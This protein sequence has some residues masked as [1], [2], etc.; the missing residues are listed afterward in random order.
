MDN[1]ISTKFFSYLRAHKAQT[2]VALLIISGVG[3]YGYQKFTAKEVLPQYITA[4]VERGT[5]IV[6]VSGTGQVASSNQIDVKPKASGT[7]VRVAVQTGKEVAADSVLIELDDSDALKTVRDA[8]VNLESAKLSLDKLKQSADTLSIL[9]SENALVSAK[10][11][12]EKLKLSQTTDYEKAQESKQKALDNITKAYEDAFNEIS[13]SFLDLP[14]IMTKLDDILHGQ[15]IGKADKSIGSGYINTSTLI[16]TLSNTTDD[17]TKIQPFINY[18][19]NDYSAAR[20]AYNVNLLSYQTAS[21]FSERS[22]TEVLLTETIETTKRVTEAAKSQT[23]LFDTW[24]DLR[25]L[26]N[27]T[28]YQQVASKVAEYRANL[29]TYNG[30]VN[31]HLSNLL[32]VQRTLQDNKD[33]VV[34]ADRDLK[35]MDQ[36]NPLDLS[37]AE[38]AVKEKEVS[39]LKL[40]AGADS[41]DIQT[42]ELAI[43]QRE[44][45]LADARQK[46][47]DYTVRAPLAGVVAKLNV[48]LGDPAS[49]STAVATLIAKQKIAEVS[50]NEVDVAK[51]QVGQKATLTFDAVQGL[52]IT[53]DVVEIETI[54][55]VSQGVVSYNVKIGFD[56]QD[57]RIKPGMSVSAAIITDVR[58]DVLMVTG[59]AVKSQNGQGSYVEM[60]KDGTPERRSVEVGLSNDSV[61]EVSGDIREGEEVVTQTITSESSN[62]TTQQRSGG[63]LFPVGGFRVGGGR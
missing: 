7:V 60:L 25:T 37:A 17:R 19:E 14:T 44:N 30:Q 35:A 52:T 55:T 8:S 57:E 41:L 49:S 16:N 24:T 4:P 15:E 34:S 62:T 12:L 27:A 56:T 1:R 45:A 22:V 3:Y 58:Q 2:F 23:T 59:S 33:A 32:A 31:G 29:T 38:Q 10:D 13:N 28:D 40:K 46:L 61:T 39:L 50:L 36:N 18:A 63:S 51:V 47:A 26:R 54:G 53:G 42:Q 21:R 11:N 20:S 43:R 5:L 6:S 9:Q 48:K